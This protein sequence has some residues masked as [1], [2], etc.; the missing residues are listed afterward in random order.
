MQNPITKAARYLRREY[1]FMTTMTGMGAGLGAA[2]TTIMACATGTMF[3]MIPL[4][5]AGMG[6]GV[7]LLSLPMGGEHNRPGSNTVTLNGVKLVGNK[8][9]IASIFMTQQLI[10]DYSKKMQHLPELPQRTMR[11]I[12]AHLFDIR[13]SLGRVRAYADPS[14][15]ALTS[16]PFTRTMIDGQGQAIAQ[17][18]VTC[19]LPFAAQP[20]PAAPAP[21]VIGAPQ[22]LAAL[23]APK[24]DFAAA[25]E[26]AP[27]AETVEAKPPANKPGLKL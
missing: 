8:R 13:G 12:A 27:Q 1:P 15:E 21:L 3:L 7:A 10:D 25:V 19:N 17:P 23:P 2:V 5:A 11:R 14:G 9:D 4:V 20:L 16:F 18:I 24:A 26:Q 22:P 6:G